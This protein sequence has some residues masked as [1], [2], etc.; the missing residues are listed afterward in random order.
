MLLQREF[1][2][3]RSINNET[4]VQRNRPTFISMEFSLHKLEE[5]Q[6]A[7]LSLSFELVLLVFYL[8]L[9]IK[10]SLLPQKLILHTIS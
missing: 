6:K 1:R 3:V 9:S 10:K 4:P 2:Y 5:F 8:L 7:I